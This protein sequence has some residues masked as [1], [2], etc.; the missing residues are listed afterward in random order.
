MAEYKNIDSSSNSLKELLAS[1]ELYNHE[2]DMWRRMAGIVMADLS[3]DCGWKGI[4]RD[5]DFSDFSG[6][7]MEVKENEVS[8]WCNGVLEGTVCPHGDSVRIEGFEDFSTSEYMKDNN[9]LEACGMA[10]RSEENINKAIQ[11][12][13]NGY[14]VLCGLSYNGSTVYGLVV[15]DI[16]IKAQISSLYSDVRFTSPEAVMKAMESYMERTFKVGP[17]PEFPKVERCFYDGRTVYHESYLDIL[18]H[19]SKE[20]IK[21]DRALFRSLDLGLV[22]LRKE[23]ETKVGVSPE[24]RNF[25]FENAVFPTNFMRNDAVFLCKRSGTASL[26]FF[27]IIDGRIGLYDKLGFYQKQ[28]LPIK[29]FSTVADALADARKTILSEKNIDIA[30]KEYMIYNMSQTN[31]RKLKR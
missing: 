19:R 29:Q 9:L 20:Q 8:L 22:A 11:E 31:E 10:C 27:S 30:K 3:M 13:R 5:M 15:S 23:F 4:K 26:G 28:N 16:D 21:E 2:F 14:E 24:H 6:Y 7:Y 12:M 18:N 1:A 25:M 17:E